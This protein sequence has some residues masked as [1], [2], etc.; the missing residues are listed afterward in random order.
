MT[1]ARRAKECFDSCEQNVWTCSVVVRCQNLIVANVGTSS[2][3]MD[4]CD[5]G[6]KLY[7]C[8]VNPTFLSLVLA[9]LTARQ[10]LSTQWRP[11]EIAQDTWA[12][13]CQLATNKSG[14]E[15]ISFVPRL[16]VKA[17]FPGPSG[18]LNNGCQAAK[19]EPGKPREEDCEAPSGTEPGENRSFTRCSHVL[20][21]V[22]FLNCLGNLWEKGSERE[23]TLQNHSNVLD[24]RER[25]Q[26][27]VHSSTLLAESYSRRILHE[28]IRGKDRK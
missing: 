17:E 20:L 8:L 13:T 6:L 22:L 7:H 2:T 27:S 9:N 14:G 1:F 15:L 21:L 3:V 12:K 26:N 11:A 18:F 16:V 5:M 23:N 10:L 25:S 19:I 4:K 24:G 28:F